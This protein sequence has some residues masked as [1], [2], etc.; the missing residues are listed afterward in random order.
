[1]HS[2]RRAVYAGIWA[3][4]AVMSKLNADLLKGMQAADVRKRMAIADVEYIGSTPLQCDAFLRGQ[5]SVWGTIVRA[6]GARAD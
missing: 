1:M 3:P 2:I 5:V 6:S 4:P